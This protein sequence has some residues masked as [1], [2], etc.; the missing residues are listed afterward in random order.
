MTLS[1]I[2][3]VSA[4]KNNF[5]STDKTHKIT[6]LSEIATNLHIKK[7]TMMYCTKYSSQQIQATVRIYFRFH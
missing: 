4:D 3:L 2:N 7:L 6:L 5:T 1:K